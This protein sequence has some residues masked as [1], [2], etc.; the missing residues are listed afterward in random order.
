MYTVELS[1]IRGV[2]CRELAL[3]VIRVKE[4]GLELA[5]SREERV[6]EAAKAGG[7]AKA[8]E[9]LCCERAPDDEGA[10]CLARD[11]RR[12]ASGPGNLTEKVVEGADRAAEQS[13]L[14][15]QQLPLSLL[16]VRPVRHDQVRL[17]R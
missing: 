6:S 17:P 12:L 4:P 8:I 11:P 9:R 16:D 3:Q 13:R 5:D 1:A 2:Q 7:A 15:G 10:L 14:D